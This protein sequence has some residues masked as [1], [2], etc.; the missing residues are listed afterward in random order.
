MPST[1]PPRPIVADEIARN[2][3]EIGRFLTDRGPPAS[4]T[5]AARFFDGL[6]EREFDRFHRLW[7]AVRAYVLGHALQAATEAELSI[8]DMPDDEDGHGALVV[9]TFAEA[10]LSRARGE[11]ERGGNLYLDARPPGAQL[12]AFE[13]LRLRTP[14]IPFAYAAGNRA[15]LDTLTSPTDV[16]LLEIGIGRAQQ[17]RAL[18][19][20]PSARRL[21]RSLRVIGVEPDSSSATGSGALELAEQNVREAAEEAGL[22]ASF[23][24]IAK[25]A[26]ELTVDDIRSAGP[27][28][29]LLANAAFALHHV[30]ED[31]N[32]APANR[33]AVLRTLRNA[34]VQRLVLVEPDSH[35]F[36]DDLLV[37]FLYAFRHYA[38]I[39][40]S[41]SGIMSVADGQLV[42]NEFFAPEVRNIIVHEGA[43]RTERHEEIAT[44]SDRLRRSGWE[45]EELRDLVPQSAAPPS[46]EVR[47]RQFGVSLCFTDVPLLSVLRAKPA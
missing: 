5:E 13:L 10:V 17:T 14:L 6:S 40:A 2:R 9:R 33:D 7:T 15:L 43:R 4:A 1:M 18:L 44:W 46:F 34:G 35:H 19:R 23:H 3:Q 21:I 32:G 45:I 27:V 24:P 37:R 8:R 11:S 12:R 31:G 36:E 41:L 38:S 47:T 28:G 22:A 30:A 42:W 26:E 20:N 25:R 39:A 16:T 29:L